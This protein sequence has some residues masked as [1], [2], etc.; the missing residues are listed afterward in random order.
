MVQD[1]RVGRGAAVVCLDIVGIELDGL[2]GISY[3]EAIGLE[4]DVGL[5]TSAQESRVRRETEG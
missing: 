5:L 1:G 3:G 2:V 4:L